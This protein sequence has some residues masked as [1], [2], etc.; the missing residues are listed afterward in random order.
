[1]RGE[2]RLAVFTTRMPG[3]RARRPVQPGSTPS[4]PCEAR[5]AGH[6]DV[7]RPQACKRLRGREELGSEAALAPRR[8]QEEIRLLRPPDEPDQRDSTHHATTVPRRVRARIGDDADRLA[9]NPQTCS[10]A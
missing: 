2:H 6:G 8:G 1:M 7:A 5:R 10:A 3:S 9:E 4:S